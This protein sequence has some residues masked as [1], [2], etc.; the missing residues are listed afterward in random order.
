MTETVFTVQAIPNADEATAR[1]LARIT[2]ADIANYEW[3]EFEEAIRNGNL[4]EV[5]EVYL[6]EART[7]WFNLRVPEFAN[8]T[9]FDETADYFI[10]RWT[11]EYTELGHIKGSQ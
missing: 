8:S 6:E 3:K 1:R 10:Q 7:V 5:A 2:I 4:H 9:I 11:K